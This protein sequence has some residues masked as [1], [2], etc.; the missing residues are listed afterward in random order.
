MSQTQRRG[1]SFV[2]SQLSGC[3]AEGQQWARLGKLPTVNRT[4]I[5]EDGRK[6]REMA[7]VTV[8]GSRWIRSERQVLAD[9]ITG[10][11]F[12]PNTGRCFSSHRHHLE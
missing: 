9:K 5:S 3:L 1:N 7:Y 12:D 6:V 10:V 2:G 4:L 8:E 11:C